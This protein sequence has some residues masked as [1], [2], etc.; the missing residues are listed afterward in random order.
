MKILLVEDHKLLS[1]G[2]KNS[3]LDFEV[4]SEVQSI[5]YP[6]DRRSVL[7]LI[8]RESFDI[9]LLDINIKKILDIDGLSLAGLILE[10]NKDEK[11]V[12][13]TGYDYYGLEKEAKDLG[14]A[15]FLNKDLS[16]NILIKNLESILEGDRIFKIKEDKYMDLTERE[17]DIINLYARGISR[18]QVCD[19][20][21]ISLRTLANHLSTIYDKLNVNN[22]QEMIHEATL[23]GYVKDNIM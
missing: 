9:I 2:L 13:L 8:E 4:V 5:D 17:K 16:I 6:T 23:L 7:N 19:Y 11:V 21:N 3:L 15:G 14:A 20:L 1:Q 22:Y 18:N 12:I 10:Q